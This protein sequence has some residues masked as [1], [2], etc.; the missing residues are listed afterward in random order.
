MYLLYRLKEHSHR[1]F[2]SFFCCSSRFSF[3]ASFSLDRWHFEEEEPEGFL[4][5]KKEEEEIFN[6]F[7]KATKQREEKVTYISISIVNCHH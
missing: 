1:V 7:E 3:S 4:F 2:L 6:L 5:E